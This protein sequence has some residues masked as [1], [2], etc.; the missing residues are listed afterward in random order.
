MGECRGDIRRKKD[1]R[2]KGVADGWM[3]GCKREASSAA[4]RAPLRIPR[5]LPLNGKRSPGGHWGDFG[6]PS[7][8]PADPLS[9]P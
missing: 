1:D 8:N 2:G 7:A 3:G 6:L 5:Q 9:G 4:N